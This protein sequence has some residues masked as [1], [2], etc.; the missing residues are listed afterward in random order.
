VNLQ[1]LR[2]TDVSWI[3]SEFW[4][5]NGGC[6]GCDDFLDVMVSGQNSGCIFC[7]GLLDLIL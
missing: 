5:Q 4:E 7:D 6:N 3:F 1:G 2:L